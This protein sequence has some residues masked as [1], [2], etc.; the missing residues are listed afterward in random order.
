[1][2]IDKRLPGTFTGTDLQDWLAERDAR[3]HHD[4]R[5]H[6]QRLLRHD[7]APGAPPGLGA[8]ILHDAVGVPAM[9]GVDGRPIDAETLHGAALAP[10]GL[11]GVELTSTEDW[12]GGSVVTGPPTATA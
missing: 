10:L 4:R 1:M 12:I 3:P 2:L 11:I 9:P 6:D 8:T 7:G 5:L